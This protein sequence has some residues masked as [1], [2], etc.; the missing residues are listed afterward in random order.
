MN[1]LDKHNITKDD[2]S[3]HLI[4]FLVLLGAI[5]FIFQQSFSSNTSDILGKHLLTNQVETP[6][7]PTTSYTHNEQHHLTTDAERQQAEKEF[8][9]A[10]QNRIADPE[11]QGRQ[12]TPYKTPREK[13]ALVDSA[14]TTTTPLISRPKKIQKTP[15]QQLSSTR[16]VEE[17][18]KEPIA[19]SKKSKEVFIN[20]DSPPAKI[21]DKPVSIKKPATTEIKENLAIAQPNTANTKISNL[22]EKVASKKEQAVTNYE[23]TS[24]AITPSKEQFQEKGEGIAAKKPSK[25][26]KKVK[27]STTKK[28]AKESCAII[29][30]TLQDVDNIKRLVQSL[31]SDNYQIYNRRSGKNR[32]VGIKTSCN[33]SVHQPLLQTIQRKYA[34]D[35]W[36]KRQ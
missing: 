5:G 29:V 19:T 33:P 25:P 26:K 21:A 7:L 16:I 36:L 24:P 32:A 22:Q 34:P 30:A 35:A 14:S 6:V 11:Q 3:D 28:V 4:A 23:A 27:K 10:A 20:T 8:Y 17:K 9:N 31:K 1:P 2:T 13:A 15:T 12:D 18:I